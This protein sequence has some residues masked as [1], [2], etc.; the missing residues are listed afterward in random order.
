[1]RRLIGELGDG[2]IPW[3][4][5]P[6]TYRRSIEDIYLHARKAGRNPEDIDAAVMVFTSISR[7]GEKAR[8]VL[9]ERTR[10]VLALRSRLLRDLGYGKLA[11]EAF[12]IWNTNF[13][14]EQLDKL[15]SIADK[16]PLEA[17][18]AVTAAGTP[19]EAIGRIEEYLKAGV[20]LFI[21]LPFPVNFEETISY[22]EKQVIPYFK[23]YEA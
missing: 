2:W 7:D 22:L 4:E 12:D 11:D 9:V 17:V 20:K 21:A 14:R 8:Q 5:S 6:K 10:V 3:V 13:T 16:I 19:D 1:M 18:E 23:S 15:Y